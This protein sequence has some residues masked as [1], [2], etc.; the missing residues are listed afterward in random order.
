MTGKNN[1]EAEY[2]KLQQ[3]YKDFA[4]AVSHDLNAPLRHIKEFLRIMFD[5]LGNKISGPDERFK[6]IILDATTRTEKILQ[7][8]V[9]FSRLNNPPALK[10]I[11]LS[12]VVTTS[13]QKF[14]DKIKQ[15]NISVITELDDT[16]VNADKDQIQRLLD[17]LIHNA[18]KFFNAPSPEIKITTTENNGIITIKISDNGIG[19]EERFHE[20]VFKPMRALHAQEELR[21]VGMGLTIAQKIVYNHNGIIKISSNRERGITVTI[22]LPEKV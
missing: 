22:E 13:L 7:S 10:E 2:K 9:D 12:N 16:S 3:E 17:E 11:K 4:Y 5:S 19:I 8:L 20:E 18:V 21:G 6:N 15:N 14:A 1:I